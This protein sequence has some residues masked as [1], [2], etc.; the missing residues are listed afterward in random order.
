MSLRG[1]ICGTGWSLVVWEVAER[2][3]RVGL[4]FRYG[5]RKL[6]VCSEGI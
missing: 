3:M 1:L 5:V 2:L 4:V 6:R